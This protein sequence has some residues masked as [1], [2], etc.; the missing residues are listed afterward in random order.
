MISL[1]LTDI[2]VTKQQDTA[3]NSG[4]LYKDIAL[5]LKPSYYYVGQINRSIPLKD[6]QALYDLEA[7]KNSVRTC[8]L[9]SPGQKI[10]NPIYGVD[11]R[12]WLFE[13]INND[14]AYFIA[15]DINVKLPTFEPRIEIR[16]VSVVPN[17]E[18]QQYDVTL[19]IDIPSLNIYGVSLR[20]YL[21]SNGYF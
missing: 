12:R 14:T 10:L 21:N 8:F 19:Q 1:K 18:E 9:T 13:P 4:H 11:L 17:I 5:D 3:L 7:I 16:N 20:N 2:S 6:V 15:D